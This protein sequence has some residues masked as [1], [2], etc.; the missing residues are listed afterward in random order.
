MG[1]R[2]D[3]GRQSLAPGRLLLP[4]R[5]DELLVLGA[6]A[7]AEGVP[8]LRVAFHHAPSLRPVAVGAVARQPGAR[9]FDVE[10]KVVDV[11]GDR[12]SVGL[13]RARGLG[14]RQSIDR[15]E[16][17]GLRIIVDIEGRGSGGAFEC[18]L[19]ENED[20][21]DGRG[22]GGRLACGGH[23]RLLS[24]L[25][26]PAGS[27]KV[28]AFCGLRL[29]LSTRLFVKRSVN[30]QGKES[31]NMRQTCRMAAAVLT[32]LLRSN[33]AG[34]EDASKSPQA[35]AYQES[36]KAIASGDFEACKKTV[37][38]AARAGIEKD[39]KEMNMDAKKGMEMLKEMAPKDIKYT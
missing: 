9:H 2:R 18:L 15:R 38:K 32:A 19:E 11:P 39:M 20:G 33:P 10:R 31:A 3:G 1:D 7:A 14:R 16:K 36:L 6:D 21:V 26:K 22:L 24:S 29:P 17:A 13:R 12:R 25:G 27:K 35:K 28:A 37:T 8:F 23:A 4:N 34:A 5:A 30:R